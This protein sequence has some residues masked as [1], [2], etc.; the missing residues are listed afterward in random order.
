ML[1]RQ[2]TT[3]CGQTNKPSRMTKLYRYDVSILLLLSLI[4]TLFVI[5]IVAVIDEF[6]KFLL[7]YTVLF[8]QMG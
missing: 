2:P 7:L 5:V 4:V 1:L 8:Q 3:Q 6:A